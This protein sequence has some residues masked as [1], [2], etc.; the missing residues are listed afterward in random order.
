MLVVT[1][2]TRHI[3]H[4]V[5]VYRAIGRF[6]EFDIRIMHDRKAVIVDSNKS[7]TAL[8]ALRVL[9]I[10]GHARAPV[11]VAEVATG[12]GA[13]RSTAYR[14]LMT[15]HDAGYVVR[16]AAGKSYQLGYRLLSLTGALLDGAEHAEV[17]LSA[18]RALS[19]ETGETVHYCVLD[20]DASVLVYRAKGTQLVSVDF[21]IGDRG[22]LHCTSIGKALL[23]Y[24]DA[25][26]VEEVIARGLPKVA[27]N[28][29]IDPDDFRAELVKVRRQGFAFDDLEFHDDMRCVAVPIFEGGG[30]VR[31]G[32]SL[33]GPASR[34]SLAKL[35]EL[36]NKSV[37]TARDL[38][39]RIGGKA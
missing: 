11:G 10:V 13:D 5:N 23:A 31:A 30:V 18:I 15:L 36:K 25:R 16:D 3:M 1:Q 34:Y 21:K 2:F 22:A 39:K 27:P 24:Q 19:D 8:R 4:I 7:T 9:E 37:V 32:I 26:L 33:S 29:I 20:R 38:A 35:E 12:I 14:M 28:T 6:I 17:I